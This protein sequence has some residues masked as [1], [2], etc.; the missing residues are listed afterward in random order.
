MNLIHYDDAASLVVDALR[1]G[2]K[3]ATY[4]GCDSV[5]RTR[6]AL[7][8]AAGAALGGGCV[9]TGDSSS[10]GGSGRA[11]DNA[12]TR[13]ALGGWTPQWVSFEACM[14]AQAK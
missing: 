10:E 9:F 4:L 5:P 6:Q 1:H 12:W 7:A 11:M 14:Q 8:D 13:Q 2:S 3:G